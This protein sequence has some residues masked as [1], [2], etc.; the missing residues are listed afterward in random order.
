MNYY[1][2]IDSPSK[3]YNKVL[4]KEDR[5]RQGINMW[6]AGREIEEKARNE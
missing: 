5:W 1:K 3:I 4:V 6:K 2:T